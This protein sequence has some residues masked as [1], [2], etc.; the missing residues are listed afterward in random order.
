MTDLL[1]SPSTRRVQQAN[2]TR[3]MQL[4]RQER[5]PG[6]RDYASLYRFSIDSPKAFWRAVWEFGGVVG[7]AG[8]KTVEHFVLL[9]IFDYQSFL[10]ASIQ[11]NHYL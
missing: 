5:D 6:V 7:S 8:N 9:S 1:W 4:V 11:L 10:T 3:F 2:I